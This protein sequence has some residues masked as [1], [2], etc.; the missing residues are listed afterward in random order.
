MTSSQAHTIMVHIYSVKSTFWWLPGEQ[1]FS[2][3]PA[4]M[5]I[6]RHPGTVAVPGRPVRQKNTLPPF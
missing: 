2:L 4:I 6:E 3:V 5:M 1:Q